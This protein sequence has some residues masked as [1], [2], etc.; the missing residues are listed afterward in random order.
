MNKYQ[1][2]YMTAKKELADAEEQTNKLETNFLRKKGFNVA[3]IYC[4]SDEQEFNK[5]NEEFAAD[6]KVQK[7][8]SYLCHAKDIEENAEESL[9][10]YVLSIIPKKEREILRAKKNDW[11]IRQQVLKIFIKGLEGET[12]EK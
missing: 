3:H 12:H 5:L 10:Q 2:E 1:R 9:I 7:I 6:P 11:N 8:W 4:I